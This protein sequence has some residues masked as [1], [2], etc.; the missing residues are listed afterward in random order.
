M[1][2]G[3]SLPNHIDQ[4]DVNVRTF[5]CPVLLIQRQRCGSIC[6]ATDIFKFVTRFSS[7]F[8]GHRTGPASALAALRLGGQTN[9]GGGRRGSQEEGHEREARYSSDAFSK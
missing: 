9:G 4:I 8:F 3:D 6:G 2:G 1:R 5:R 7:P